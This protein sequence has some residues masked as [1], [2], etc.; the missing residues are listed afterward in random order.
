MVTLDSLTESLFTADGVQALDRFL[1]DERGV[2]GYGLMQKAAR[3]AFRQ[4]LR[5]W[6]SAG[7][8]VVLCGAGNNGGDGYLVALNALRHGLEVTCVAVADPQKLSGDARKAWRDA[9]E[10]GVPMTDWSG[11]DESKKAGLS[12]DGVVLVDAMLGTGAR[13]RP[14]SPVDEVI[15]W[16]NGSGRPVLAVDVP[17]GLDASLGTA[18]GEAVQADVTATFIGRKLGLVTGKGPHYAGQVAYETLGAERQ[19]EGCKVEPVAKL[20][21]WANRKVT[22]PALS[23]GAHKGDFGHVLIIA[24]D[25]GFGGA[26]LLAAEAA[27]RSGAGLVSLATRP[28]HV[29]AALSRCPSLMVRGVEHGNDLQ[30]L[31]DKADAVVCGPGIGQGAW[32]RQMLQQVLASDKPR[33]LDADALNLLATQAPSAEACQVITP[34]PGEAARLLA[35]S[36]ADVEA[37]RLAAVQALQQRYG[38]VALLKG[39]GTLVAAPDQLPV[40]VG[41][42]NPGMAT[43]G[44]GDVLSGI[45]GGFLAQAVRSRAMALDDAVVNAATLHLAAANVASRRLGYRALL[46]SDVMDAMAPVLMAAESGQ[47]EATNG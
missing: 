22:L 3:A 6:P 7:H 10:A 5:H 24:G 34:H 9:D 2:E 33:L 36:V 12:G 44:M 8:V 45:A 28:E 18:E 25:H 42:A 16:V 41:G 46:P 29:A 38:G 21:T 35:C 20:A 37:D 26:G 15:A 31:L 30:S 4:V 11:L 17:S 43:G 40:V 23:P 1:I 14:R 39:A 19:I 27:A 47:V 13:G 32:G